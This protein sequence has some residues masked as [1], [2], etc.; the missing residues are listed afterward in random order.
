MFSFREEIGQKI[1][2]L[3]SECNMPIYEHLYYSSS[4]NKYLQVFLTHRFNL[5]VIKF[6]TLTK[7][8]E[9]I[10]EPIIFMENEIPIPVHLYKKS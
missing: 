8:G 2:K 9:E 3:K 6:T 10:I 7:F 4:K 5:V 1:Q